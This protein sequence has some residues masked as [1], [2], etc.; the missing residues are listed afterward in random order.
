VVIIGGGPAGLFAAYELANDPSI[1]VCIIDKGKDIN[2]RKCPSM[3]RFTRCMECKPCNILCGLGGAG[4]LS[5][6]KLN[7]KADVGG[8]L[9]EFVSREEAE[10]L[11]HKIDNIFLKHGAS[12]K[13]YGTNSIDL[14]KNMGLSKAEI[15]QND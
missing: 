11:I 14:E 13:L 10:S 6:G 15:E 3:T 12:Q 8:N 7:L 2:E 4:G 1:K 5:D 9:E